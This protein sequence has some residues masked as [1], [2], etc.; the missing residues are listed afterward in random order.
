M[1]MCIQ[2]L[3]K[4]CPL[5]HNEKLSGNEMVT[6]LLNNRIMEGQ[7]KSSIAPLFHRGGIIN[8]FQQFYNNCYLEQDLLLLSIDFIK[9]WLIYNWL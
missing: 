7:G 2:N 5:V 4:F 3:V 6:E 8:L 9:D 1:L